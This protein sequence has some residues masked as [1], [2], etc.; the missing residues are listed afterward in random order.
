MVVIRRSAVK[1]ERFEDIHTWQEARVLA[2]LVYDMSAEGAFAKDFGLRDQI[3]EA[4]GSVM[5]NIAEGF[6]AG[7]DTEFIPFLK[8]AR[9]STSE[10]QSEAYLA[11]DRRYITQEQF[12]AIYDQATKTKKLINA[13]IAYLRKSKRA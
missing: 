6:D 12:Q 13:F 5:H 11:L 9:R 2:N 1:I 10:V 4:A 3:R 8:Y 7:S